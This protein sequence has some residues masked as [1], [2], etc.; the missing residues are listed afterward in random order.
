MRQALRSAVVA[1]SLTACGGQPEPAAD[2]A[3]R[4]GTEPEVVI[5]EVLA[6]ADPVAREAAIVEIL[7]AHPGETGILC[8]ALAEGPVRR[9]CERY[10][11]RP[12]L[13]TIGVDGEAG[14]PSAASGSRP[15][16]D[17]RPGG[18]PLGVRG[19]LPELGVA[20]AVADPG[21]CSEGRV[22][23]LEAEALAA[24][25]A[26]EPERAAAR[27]A[28]LDTDRGRQDCFFRAAEALPRG[29]ER[30]GEGTA[31]CLQAG[32]FA[33]ECHGHL[34]LALSEG[35]EPAL[36]PAQDAAAAALAE[37]ITAWWAGRD[38]AFGALAVDAFWARHLDWQRPMPLAAFAPAARTLPEAARP[39]L[40]AALAFRV[41]EA[42][43]P[44]A[45]AQAW[46]R[47]T[48]PPVPEPR[49]EGMTQRRLW[50]RDLP[51]EEQLRAARLPSSL[52]GRRPVHPDL[53]TDVELVL[54]ELAARR[55]EGDIEAVAARAAHPDPLVRWSVARI[56]YWL[57]VDHPVRT[58]LS[59]DTDPLVARR[60]S[61]KPL[62]AEDS[63]EALHPEA[64]RRSP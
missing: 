27:C 16:L 45:A 39:H 37:G 10:N 29:P 22:S 20:P 57:D 21:A 64:A 26:G 3:S 24:A 17:H 43:D 12:H 47:G 40:V 4:F 31:L 1:L 19:V 51:G 5:A 18:G 62:R 53:A 50:L 11:S 2:R 15:V 52:D 25:A 41:S 63:V 55:G 60:A 46:W 14:A 42:A 38:P 34:I 35:V 13:W 56:L 28:A 9:R 23:C 7:E 49:H 48:G 30:Y 33:P 59:A 58:E 32:T 6:L 8:E 36:D 44:V 54:L 61:W